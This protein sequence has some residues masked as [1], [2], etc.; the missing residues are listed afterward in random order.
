M[1]GECLNCIKHLSNPWG[2]PHPGEAAVPPPT[3][4]RGGCAPRLPS[5]VVPLPLL[6]ALASWN[7]ILYN[8]LFLK[9]HVNTTVHKTGPNYS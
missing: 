5:G 1:S 2:T 3:L 9:Q 6:A 4:W 7:Y 8:S